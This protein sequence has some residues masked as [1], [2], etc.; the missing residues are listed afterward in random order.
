MGLDDLSHFDEA[1][2]RQHLRYEYDDEALLKNYG[3]KTRQYFGAGAGTLAT[4]LAALSGGRLFWGAAAGYSARRCTVADR[5]IE[6]IRDE[7]RA[8]G[9][10]A[11]ETR[12]RDIVAPVAVNV[13]ALG[14]K[15]ALT[16]PKHSEPE[17]RR[18][19]R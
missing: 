10:E 2:Y 16:K 4:G 1:E 8:R 18:R 14:V 3:K 9:L 15:Y 5:K 13:M 12:K 7:I 11:P 17:E 6:C 19:R